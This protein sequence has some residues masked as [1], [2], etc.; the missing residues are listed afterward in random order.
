MCDELLHI[1]AVLLMILMA[2]S[3][4]QYVSGELWF[5]YTLFFLGC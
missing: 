3:K 1:A 5:P 2:Q 4:L